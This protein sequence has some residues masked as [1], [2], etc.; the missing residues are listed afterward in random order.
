MQEP[1]WVEPHQGFEYLPAQVTIDRSDQATKLAACGLD[2]DLYGDH[3]DPSQFIS[4]AIHAGIASGIS[5]EGNINM[6]QS[7]RQYRPVKLGEPLEVRG[8]ITDVKRVPRGETVSTD[9]WFEDPDGQ[10]IVSARRRSLRPLA[11]DSHTRGAGERPP[12]VVDD[13][14]ELPSLGEHQLTPDGVQAYSSKGNAIHYDM[15]AANRAGFRTPMIGG[16]M[17]VHFLVAAMWNQRTFST[18]ELDI[19]F[20]RPIFWDAAFTVSGNEKS[21]CLWTEI[22]RAHV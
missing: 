12:P 18:L 15:A 17:G 1:N 20:R 22:G 13:P 19:Y 10:R 2:A 11:D 6:V 8:L 7:L 3:V 9:V 21:I 4:L 5:A 16:A 14:T